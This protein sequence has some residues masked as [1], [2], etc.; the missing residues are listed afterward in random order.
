MAV[1]FGLFPGVGAVYNRQHLKAIVHFLGVVGLAQCAA[2]AD[3]AVFGFGAAAFYIYTLIDAFRTAR[4]IRAGL[5]PREDEL[6]GMV[7]GAAMRVLS[8]VNLSLDLY[9]MEEGTYRLRAQAVPL[10]CREW[11][12]L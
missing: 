11:R 10:I 7:E 8:M 12:L 3:L 1:F 4:D 2:V 6:V 5:D 9:R